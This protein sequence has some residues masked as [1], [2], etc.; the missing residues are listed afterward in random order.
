[1]DALQ[2]KLPQPDIFKS[3]GQTVNNVESVVDMWH[4][5]LFNVFI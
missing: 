1:M 2:K 3:A 5:C 4:L